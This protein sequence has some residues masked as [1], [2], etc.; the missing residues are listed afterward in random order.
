MILESV[1]NEDR[2][3][4]LDVELCFFYICPL[5]KKKI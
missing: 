5:I 4:N 3:K 2:D 1:A